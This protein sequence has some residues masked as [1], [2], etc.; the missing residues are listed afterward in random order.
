MNL[1]FYLFSQI[2]GLAGHYLWFD[3][4]AVFFAKDFAYIVPIPLVLLLIKDRKKYF[5]MVVGAFGSGIIARFG[6]VELIRFLYPRYR[7]FVNNHVNLLIG[8]VH[9]RSLPSGHAA[10]FFAVSTFVYYYNKK[11][12]VIFFFFSFLISFFRVYVGIHWPADIFTGAI[13]GILTSLV[14]IKIYKKYFKK[15]A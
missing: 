11:A 7:P 4:I 3:R 12:G 1:D 14:L 8:E 10:F 5:K 15:N 13:V 6:V 9:Q 2:N